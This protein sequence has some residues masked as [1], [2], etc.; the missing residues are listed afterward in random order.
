[1]DKMVHSAKDKITVATKK[2]KTKITST[3]ISEFIIW[4]IVRDL[5]EAEVALIRSGLYV[6]V[7]N[8]YP[9]GAVNK[10]PDSR[11]RGRRQARAGVGGRRKQG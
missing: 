2:D 7:V 1:M 10:E 4:Q 8:P 9:R 11:N 3:K 6:P 5:Y